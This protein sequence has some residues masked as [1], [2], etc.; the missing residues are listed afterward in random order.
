MTLMHL[1]D[2]ICRS[3]CEK[4][5][6]SLVEEIVQFNHKNMNIDRKVEIGE[7]PAIAYYTGNREVFA[8]RY[9]SRKNPLPHIMQS[10]MAKIRG[11]KELENTS[12]VKF[13]FFY[14][15]LILKEAMQRTL[16]QSSRDILGLLIGRSS[17]PC[18]T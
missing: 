17:K 15:N 10:S 16:Y 7:G 2:D 4:E 1:V 18:E 14:Q 6:H 13:E 11:G 9:K 12:S 3:R 8:I 5:M